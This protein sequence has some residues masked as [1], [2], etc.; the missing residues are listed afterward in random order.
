LRTDLRLDWDTDMQIAA[1]A[2]GVGAS[3]LLWGMYRA[4]DPQ[5]L[6][7]IVNTGDDLEMH[8][9]Y[10]C[11][12]L[13][14][15]TY[16]LA[17]V[18]NPSTGWGIEGDTFATLECLGKYGR[19]TWFNLGDRDLA[20]HIHRTD[21]LRQ[22][23]MLSRCADV[24]RTSLGVRAHILPMSNERVRTQ[25]ETDHGTLP[26]QDY[27]VK[28]RATPKI[29]GIRFEGAD[30]SRP[31]A[32]VI[33][34]LE[35]AEMIVICP[36]N[37]LISIG[38]ILA[39]PGIRD[40]LARNRAK[41]VAVCPIVGGASLKGPS[42]KMMSELGLEVSATGVARLYREIASTLIIDE[43]DASQRGDIEALGL[44]VE[45]AQSIMRTD[46]DKERLAKFVMFAGQQRGAAAQAQRA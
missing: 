13:D 20:T 39:V 33:E 7:I 16:T 14:I 24:I 34:A 12:D 23:S 26:F 6:T 44:T 46:E 37:P 35:K 8:G 4:C 3:K 28:H 43:V 15:V 31:A 25:I 2:G 11:P 32:G 10:I 29:S 21:L 36:S 9:L 19:Q 30:S 38:P 17:G 22:G 1:L 5:D 40:A 41:V 42:D 27:L 45:T 18:V